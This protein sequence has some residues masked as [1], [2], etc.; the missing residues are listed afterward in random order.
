MHEQVEGG[1]G[2]REVRAASLMAFMLSLPIAFLALV[3][4]GS[5][6]Q[7]LYD[8][9]SAISAVFPFKPTLRALDATLNDSSQSV[10]APLLHLV[11][12]AL[13]YG[14]LASVALRRFA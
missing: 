1:E 4:S 14:A 9:T 3:P 5:V 13:A 12:L 8:V 2:A 6:S 10:L 11:A 7:T